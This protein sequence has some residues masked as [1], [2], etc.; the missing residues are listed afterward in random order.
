MVSSFC[1][2]HHFGVGVPTDESRRMF[3]VDSASAF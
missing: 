3:N 1:K 2:D